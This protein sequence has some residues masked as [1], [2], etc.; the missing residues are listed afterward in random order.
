MAGDVKATIEDTGEV[1]LKP[2]ETI[3]LRVPIKNGDREIPEV[4]LDFSL[5]TGGAK[6]RAERRYY[7]AGGPPISAGI[8]VSEDYCLYCAAEISG[9]AYEAFDNLGGQDHTEITT[10]VRAFL[11]GMPVETPATTASDA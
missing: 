5:L 4:V 6:R 8:A 2:V 10:T 1:T 3:A 7:S 11:L 9:I